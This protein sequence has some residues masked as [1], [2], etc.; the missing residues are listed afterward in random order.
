MLNYSVLLDRKEE[1]KFNSPAFLWNTKIDFLSP[2]PQQLFWSDEELA[3]IFKV[4]S[5]L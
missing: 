4:A 2:E 5:V 3:C 1:N